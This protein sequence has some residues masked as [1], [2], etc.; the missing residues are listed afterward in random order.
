[1]KKPTCV[2]FVINHILLFWL[3]GARGFEPPT[4]CTPCRHATRLRHAPR[5]RIIA[6]GSFRRSLPTPAG[7]TGERVDDLAQFAPQARRRLKELI[8]FYHLVARPLP[9]K[10]TP[11]RPTDEGHNGAQT[12]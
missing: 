3:V 1:M 12:E 10:E 7:L 4:T 8:E 11:A 9:P 5:G 6:E 2:G